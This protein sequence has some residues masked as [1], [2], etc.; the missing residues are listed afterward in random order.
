M[1][2]FQSS[3]LAM[4]IIDDF[5]KANMTFLLELRGQQVASNTGRLK[6]TIA[7]LVRQSDLEKPAKSLQGES[8]SSKSEKERVYVRLKYVLSKLYTAVVQNHICR[9]SLR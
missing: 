4:T 8:R 9:G 6:E 3:E 2:Q 7:H 5:S 1:A